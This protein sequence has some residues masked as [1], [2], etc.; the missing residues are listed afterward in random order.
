MSGTAADDGATAAEVVRVASRARVTVAVAESLTGGAVTDAL[1]AVPG[2]SACLR[3]GVVAYA[4]DVKREV[5]GV[6]ADLLRRRGA[7]HP[8]VAVAMAAGVRALLGADYGVATTGVAGP[9]P[10]DGQ[11]P[12]IV[13]VAVCG[14]HRTVVE[15]GGSPDGTVGRQAVRAAA[16][17]AALA[18]LLEEL[19]VAA[20]VRTDQDDADRDDGAPVPL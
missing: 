3:G 11:P 4:T 2:A 8:D 20:P 12:G 16:R 5:L 15:P 14:P 10:Q 7:V 1:V 19:R 18:L 13:H 9:D 6:D 17:D